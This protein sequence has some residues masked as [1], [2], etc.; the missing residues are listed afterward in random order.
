MLMR[1][2]FR[3]SAVTKA[4]GGNNGQERNTGNRLCAVRDGSRGYDVRRHHRQGYGMV[5][6]D[7]GDIVKS[8]AQ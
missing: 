4:E 3:H 6:K 8:V 2:G 5:G 1:L 7:V